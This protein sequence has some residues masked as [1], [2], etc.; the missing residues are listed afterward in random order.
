[1][2]LEDIPAAIVLSSEFEN[3]KLDI[4]IKHTE[5]RSDQ[6][7]DIIF[8]IRNNSIANPN[9]NFIIIPR[10]ELKSICKTLISLI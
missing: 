4:Y 3:K 10:E 2:E 5:P 8:G 1:M 7:I 6:Y 9:S